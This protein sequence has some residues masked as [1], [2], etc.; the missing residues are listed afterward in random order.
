MKGSSSLSLARTELDRDDRS[1]D[2]ER[3]SRKVGMAM[4]AQ[5]W[6]ATRDGLLE[7]VRWT[8]ELLELHIWNDGLKRLKIYDVLWMQISKCR[9]PCSNWVAASSG[10]RTWSDRVIFKVWYHLVVFSVRVGV[11]LAS[12]QM[13]LLAAACSEQAVRKGSK[14][15]LRAEREL[16]RV[17][18]LVS[19]SG[20]I[21]LAV[22]TNSLSL[23][24]S[25]MQWCSKWK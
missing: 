21:S 11:P 12:S 3:S 10:K 17:S 5:S 25:E 2:F 18:V 24:L 15:R 6:L 23:L 1:S 4:E 13:V 22:T 16:D 7:L 9:P 20:V 19:M 8:W 14:C